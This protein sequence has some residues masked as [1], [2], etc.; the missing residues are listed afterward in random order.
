MPQVRMPGVTVSRPIPSVIKAVPLLFKFIA[1]QPVP[2]ES[3]GFRSRYLA[4]PWNLYAALAIPARY[5]HGL[6][7]A[8]RTSKRG[9]IK[10][11]WKHNLYP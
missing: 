2:R 7:W 3:E 4:F 8:A 10:V 6:T 11:T 9:T 1:F 5:R